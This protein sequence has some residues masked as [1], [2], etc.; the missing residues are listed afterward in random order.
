MDSGL[1]HITLIIDLCHWYVLFVLFHRCTF[2]FNVSFPSPNP[3][4]DIPA[5][6]IST[7]PRSNASN[8]ALRTS[9]TGFCQFESEAETLNRRRAL[10]NLK[11]CSTKVSS[12]LLINYSWTSHFSLLECSVSSLTRRLSGWCQSGRITSEVSLNSVISN[13][14]NSHWF[15]LFEVHTRGSDIDLLCVA[16]VSRSDF[17]KLAIKQLTS[18]AYDRW[19]YSLTERSC[20]TNLAIRTVLSSKLSKPLLPPLFAWESVDT[21]SICCIALSTVRL[22]VSFMSLSVD[23][24]L[25]R[26]TRSQVKH[27]FPQQPSDG[28]QVVDVFEWI[29]R[30][31][32]HLQPARGR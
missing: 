32:S 15:P 9:L 23:S 6:L 17:F 21:E 24:F 12:R 22:I 8:E 1:F 26:K 28:R 25:V 11:V 20:L 27:L 7:P 18:A 2:S 3:I 13:I 29:Q 4:H 19:A 16:D 5:A 14:S 10:K 30:L 31:R